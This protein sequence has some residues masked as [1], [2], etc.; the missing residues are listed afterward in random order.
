MVPI[1]AHPGMGA[2]R[3]HLAQGEAQ[4]LGL[5]PREQVERLFPFVLPGLW[6]HIWEA[7]HTWH[8]ISQQQKSKAD[9]RANRTSLRLLSCS[10]CISAPVSA[11]RAARLTISS[12][13]DEVLGAGGEGLVSTDGAWPR[14]RR[15][16]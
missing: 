3:D 16:G 10:F 7:V 6:L 11:S 5:G 12:S 9:I 2:V 15:G 14:A 13:C 4:C 8:P 1:P